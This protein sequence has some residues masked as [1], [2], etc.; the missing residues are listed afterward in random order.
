M[1][2]TM[3]RSRFGRLW[4]RSPTIA[5][6]AGTA[7]LAYSI[8]HFLV[9]HASP[10]LAC[11]VAISSLSLT[12]DA[13]PRRVA[14][15][16]T[17]MVT[18]IT[19]SA[20]VVVLFGRGP[21]HVLGTALVVLGI[22]TLVSRNPAFALSAATQAMLVAVL[23]DPEGG[24]FTRAFDGAIGGACALLVTALVPMPALGRALRA[25][26]AVLRE[27]IAGAR[28]VAQALRDADSPGR[29]PRS[30]SCAVPSSA[31]ASGSS[32]STP[33]PGSPPSRPRHAA[34]AAP[35][36]DGCACTAASPAPS[37][38]CG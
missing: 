33:P 32:A 13:R 24:P 31:S 17:A 2:R 11:T 21:L 38:G 29:S 7:A 14:E 9:G 25:G 4:E 30:R 16:A 37:R 19:L 10:A 28:L 35:G 1:A 34:V 20:G 26:D 23:P 6:L 22:A 12:R 3:L 18:G 27:T 5:L 8:A 15:T 36:N